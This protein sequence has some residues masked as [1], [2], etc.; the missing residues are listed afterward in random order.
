[1]KKKE[2]Q[3]LA[4]KIALCEQVLKNNPD[5]KTKQ[6]LEL[7]IMKLCSKVKNLE[8]MEALDEAVQDILA[9]NS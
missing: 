3:Q 7:E 9:K 8:D 4:K 5:S 1:M 2:I 6:E